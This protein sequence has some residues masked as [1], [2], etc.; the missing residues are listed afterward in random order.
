MP[1]RRVH[2]EGTYAHFVT[3]SCYKR[4]TFLKPDIGKQIVLGTLNQQ[5]AEHNG[6]CSGFVIMLDHVHAIVWFPEEHQISLFMDKW[7][8]QSSKQI[9]AM[10]A[11]KFAA[12][13][14]KL[15]P[16]DPVWQARYYGFNISTEK[17]LTEKLEYMHNNP[18]RAGLVKEMCDWR[19]SSARFWQLGKAVG[20]PLSWPG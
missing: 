20:V 18:V 16:G 1:K 12:Y 13:W 14:S 7:K 17:K 3:F 9:A 2:S 19:W 6:V 8:E 4:R 15:D 5:L 11:K 10:Y